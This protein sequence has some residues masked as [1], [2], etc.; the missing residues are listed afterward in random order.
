MVGWGVFVMPGT[1]FLPV[2]GPIGTLIAMIISVAII[3]IVAANY[4]YLMRE[5]PTT[6][7]V[8]AYTKEAFGRDHAFLCSWF[9]TLSYLT[10]VFLNGTAMF[11]VVR[12][13]FGTK[14]QGAA[15]YNIAGVDIYLGEVMVSVAALVVVGILFI[16]A[17]PVLQY[18]HTILAVILFLGILL[19]T[20]TCAPHVSLT[21]V[22]G[23]FGTK[24]F[25]PAFGI[26]SIVLLA[27]WAFVGFDVVS[28]ESAH[29]RFSMKNTKWILILSII[30]AGFAYT[31]MA[32]VS[33]VAVPDGYT[34][35]S[36]YFSDLSEMHGAMSVPTFNS[37][38]TILG[39][40]GLAIIGISALAHHRRIQ[41]DLENAV[42][43]GGRQH[44]VSEI[45]Q[46]I[47]QHRLYHDDF[48]SYFIPWA[49]RP[50]LVRRFDVSGGCHWIRL[51]IRVRTE[52]GQTLQ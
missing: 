43:H 8:Y 23:A 52:D 11:V 42:D 21:D 30:M 18:V 1:T 28:L 48:C 27:P 29:F 37:A 38:V 40:K 45:Q 9:L 14:L 35:W 6:G 49:Q 34:S 41:S 39:G 50:Q 36:G 13:L 31:A 5:R 10:I 22:A 44:S 32:I 47:Q 2:A 7:G 3:L 26:F 33:I 46:N 19:I 15:S 17:K 51:H 16:V 12:T 4:I 25:S 24:G 20:I